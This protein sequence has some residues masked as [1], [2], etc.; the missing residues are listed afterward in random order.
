[1]EY[2]RAGSRLENYDDDRSHA[3]Y[4]ESIYCLLGLLECGQSRGAQKKDGKQSWF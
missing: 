3:L 2:S 1:M 4:Q